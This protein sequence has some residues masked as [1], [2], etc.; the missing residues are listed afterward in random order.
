MSNDTSWET[1]DIAI[2]LLHD[3][4]DNNVN[5][6]QISPPNVRI[7]YVPTGY[8]RPDA[9]SPNSQ[10]HYCRPN[11]S[12]PYDKALLTFSR[13]T[14]TFRARESKS[15]LMCVI[16]AFSSNTCSPRSAITLRYSLASNGHVVIPIQMTSS[17]IPAA[18]CAGIRCQEASHPLLPVTQYPW[19]TVG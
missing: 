19:T 7:I 9:A 5:I 16:R 10:A 8:D 2:Y 13:D 14:C 18:A 3:N 4:I 1:R 6:A 12:G 15:G 17:R 11:I